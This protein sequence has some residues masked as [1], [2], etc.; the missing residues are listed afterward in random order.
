M[1]FHS[2]NG[3]FVVARWTMRPALSWLV[4]PR[5]PPVL[6]RPLRF[7][8]MLVASS[9]LALAASAGCSSLKSA[10]ATNPGADGGDAATADV[11]QPGDDASRDADSNA[12]AEPKAEVC[13]QTTC[14]VDVVEK[15]LYGPVSI[16]VDG[17][18]LY[19]IEVG[20][21]P[22]VNRGELVRIKKTI[23]CATRSCF[24]VL[25]PNVLDGQL[26]GQNIYEA[27]V[28]LGQNDVCYTQSFNTNAQHSIRCFALADPNLAKRALDDG[29]GA[30][31]DLWVGGSEARWVLGSS[32]VGVAD[33]A[34]MG[35]ALVAGP[36]KTLAPG[37]V[38]SS[39]VTSDGAKVYWS[40]WGAASPQGSINTLLG[41][42]GVSAIA[43][44][45]ANPIAV[46]LHGQYL[47]WIEAAKRTVMRARADGTSASEQIATTDVNPIDLVVDA[48]GV[49]WITSGQ[50]TSGIAGSLSHAPLT[51]GGD[52]TI[53]I[54]DINLVYA[55]AADTTDVYVA[56]VGQLIAD[57]QIVRIKK[58][59]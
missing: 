31:I 46:R 56:S 42:G 52:I 13:T 20:A 28:A 23:G 47:Y 14:P 32:N 18:H 1:L 36:T 51:P 19:W 53:M 21:V 54:K 43:T 29:A 25:D 39:G 7:L 50:G 2:I 10:D 17:T 34:V 8:G 35:R 59:K 26:S 48:G 5:R 57:G 58:T 45:R 30:V 16:A 40:E 9:A 49:Y 24:D 15:G 4:V 3:D 37:R 55:L 22:P 6:I 27:H 11:A 33:G 41:D 44:G 38:A 12:D